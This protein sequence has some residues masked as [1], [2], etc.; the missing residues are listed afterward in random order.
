MTRNTFIMV[1]IEKIPQ[2]SANVMLQVK[3]DITPTV[4]SSPLLHFVFVSLVFWD[5][6]PVGP[7][8]L[9]HP[10]NSCTL[11]PPPLV[12]LTHPHNLLYNCSASLLQMSRNVHVKIS[13]RIENHRTVGNAQRCQWLFLLR[14][15]Q[16]D[17]RDQYV[18]SYS[19]ANREPEQSQSIQ[20][21]C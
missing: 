4:S 20:Q 6:S 7:I 5:R 2:L 18:I 12:P 15:E 21:F 14:K 9:S 3:A 8:R 1:A 19:T 16:Y 11:L 17:S 10:V 13:D